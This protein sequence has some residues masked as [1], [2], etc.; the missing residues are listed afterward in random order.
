MTRALAA[1]AESTVAVVDTDGRRR[2]HGAGAPQHHAR[3]TT[4]RSSSSPRRTSAPARSSRSSSRS[5]S[6]WP[7]P[8]TRSTSTAPCARRNPSPYMYLLPPPGPDGSSYAVVGSAARRRWCKVTG[9]RAITHP[10]AGSRPRGKTPEDDVRLAEE[11]LADPKERAEHVMLVD[12]GRNDLQRVCRPGTVDVVEFMDVR[13]YSHVMHIESTVVGDTRDRAQR[14]RRAGVD[15]PRGH[16]LRRA[17][18]P[19]ARPHRAL[20]AVPP[21]RLRRRGRLPRLPRRPRHGHRH[22]HRRHQGR[23]RPRAGRR[24][25]RRRLGAPRASSRSACTRPPRRC[26]RSPPPA[27]C[28][29]SREPLVVQG[30][31]RPARPRRRRAPPRQRLPALGDRRR[32]RRRARRDPDQRHRR[33]GRP[34]PRSPSPWPRRRG[35]RDRDRPAGRAPG[36]PVVAVRCWP[37]W[38]R[39]AVRVLLD[40]EGVLGPWR[41]AGRPHRLGRD[42]T[43]TRPCGRGSPSSPGRRAAR[44]PPVGAGSASRRWGGPSPRYEAPGAPTRTGPRGERV[45]SDWDRARRRED[46]TDLRPRRPTD[47]TECRRQ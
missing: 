26:A 2:R 28:G 3:A 31:R 23:R 43:P 24:R 21:R 30:R 18:A 7:A 40:P 9:R 22:P 19:R 33:R 8:P 25:H 45:A 5:G 41:R 15:L 27:R 20:R 16:A 14:L 38:P 46:P 32:R 34:R 1:P 36:L 13:R 4:R 17:Q 35:H 29:P 6:R 42:A 11:L 37:P 39:L 12:L 44:R 47:L 10:I